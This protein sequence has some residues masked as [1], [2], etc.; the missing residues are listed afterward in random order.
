MVWI[1]RETFV[2]PKPAAMLLGL[3][4]AV[5]P[6]GSPLAVSVIAAGR[7]VLPVGVTTKLYV[8]RPPG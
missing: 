1:D 4:V 8:A 2:V 5:A 3:K 6:G 7:V